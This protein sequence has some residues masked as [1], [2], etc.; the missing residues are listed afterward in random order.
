M[1]ELVVNRVISVQADGDR[2]DPVGYMKADD[3][4]RQSNPV[5]NG[6][7]KDVFPVV[8]PVEPGD[9]LFHQFP[10]K[11]WLSPEEHEIPACF[12]G[13]VLKE[14]T[15][16]FLCSFQVHHLFAIVQVNMTI[17]MV[18]FMLALRRNIQREAVDPD[19]FFHSSYFTIIVKQVKPYQISIPVSA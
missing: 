4:F 9:E 11:Q 15:G 1:F 19:L 16:R 5:R 12:L 7:E 10:V 18:T 13:D 14:E 17:A 2:P 8:L 3:L 6:K